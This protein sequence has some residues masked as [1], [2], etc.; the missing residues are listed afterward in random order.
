MA[1]VMHFP[2]SAS[3]SQS[4]IKKTDI[5]VILC[6]QLYV[7]CILCCVLQVSKVTLHMRPPPIHTGLCMEQLGNQQRYGKCISKAS[8]T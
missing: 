5:L 7:F 8:G 2:A 1:L 6:T 3:L 4:A